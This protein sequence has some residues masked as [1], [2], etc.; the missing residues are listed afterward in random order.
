MYIGHVLCTDARYIKIKYHPC[1]LGANTEVRVESEWYCSISIT[2]GLWGKVHEA[3]PEEWVT[4][5]SS[6]PFET[7]KQPDMSWASHAW[8]LDGKRDLWK[9][10]SWR[11]KRESESWPLSWTWCEWPKGFP[12]RSSMVRFAFY[13]SSF[14][15]SLLDGMGRSQK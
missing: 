4:H 9:G 11:I 1:L 8:S 15:S 2:K 3:D 5:S 6:R 7:W 12:Q 14:E 10:P 13:R